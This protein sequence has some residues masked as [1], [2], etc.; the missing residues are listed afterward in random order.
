MQLLLIKE[1]LWDIVNKVPPT[2]P[3]ANWLL[4]DKK[5]TAIIGLLVEDDQLIH[6]RDVTCARAAWLGLKEYHEKPLLSNKVLLLKRL[7]RMNLAKGENVEEHINLM[8]E[9]RVQLMAIGKNLDEDAF[10]A[11][12]SLPESY[13][14]LISGLE[15]R[16]KTDITLSLVKGK[17]IKEYQTRENIPE[18]RETALKT[19]DD[20]GREA[21]KITIKCYFCKKKGHM[22]KE[23]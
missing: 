4:N 3:D 2:I 19:Q 11:L 16:P 17:L 9:L 8:I 21:N 7:C 1:G 13:N 18:L 22:K 14:S 23:L 12:N 10:I 5:A 15:S 6:I 20:G